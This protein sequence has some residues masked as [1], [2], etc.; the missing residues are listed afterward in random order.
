M[1][2]YDFQAY[3]FANLS[4]KYI[5]IHTGYPQVGPQS[6]SKPSCGLNT[7]P[8][9]NKGSQILTGIL[10]V[11]SWQNYQGLRKGFKK[12]NGKLSTFCG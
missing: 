12:R 10:N 7:V 4:I 1:D 5:C 3:V 11:G 2:F 6:Q 9:G 8:T